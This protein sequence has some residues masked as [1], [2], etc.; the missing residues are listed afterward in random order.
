[1][2]FAYQGFTHERDIRRFTFLGI[3]EYNP[4]IIFS[5]EISLPLLFKNRVPVQEAPTF[6]LDLLTAASLGGPV[7]LERFRNYRVLEQDLRPLLVDREKRAAEK[8]MKKPPRRPFRKP[9]SL[10]NLQLTSAKER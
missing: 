7:L 3:E 6:C 1:M 9:T 8:A 4:A 10:S 2:H 5:I